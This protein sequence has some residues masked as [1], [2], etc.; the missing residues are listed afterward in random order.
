VEAM[1]QTTARDALELDIRLGIGLV[2]LIMI[3]PSA[4]EVAEQY[5]RALTLSRALPDRGRE[6]FLATWGMWFNTVLR[7]LN[8][9]AALLSDEL[10]AI[11]RELDNPDFLME[12]YH[13]KVPMLL[14]VPDF[15]GVVEAAQ[16]VI[17]LYNRERHHDHAY[18]FG[19]HDARMCARSFYAYGLWAD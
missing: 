2:Q 13:A 10:V 3:G 19:G 11:A 9:E 7:G 18:Y 5:S 17:R 8:D 12:A 4:T 15:K 16:Q 6:R 14:W 1:P